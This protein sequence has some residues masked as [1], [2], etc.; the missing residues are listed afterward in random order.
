MIRTILVRLSAMPLLIATF[1]MLAVGIAAPATAQTPQKF[2][3]FN[4]VTTCARNFPPVN[5]GVTPERIACDKT[6]YDAYV[7]SVLAS[8]AQQQTQKA[9]VKK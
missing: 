2:D 5:G 1:V 9:T 4:A 7:A 6:A 8:A 3:Y